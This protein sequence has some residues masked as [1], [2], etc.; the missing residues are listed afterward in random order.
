MIYNMERLTNRI[1]QLDKDDLIVYTKGKY[2][3][4]VPGE[5]SHDDIRAVLKKLAYYEDA[6][7]EREQ[8]DKALNELKRRREYDGYLLGSG[9][10]ESAYS[11]GYKKAVD[12]LLKNANEMS[13]EMSTEVSMRNYSIKAIGI[14][15]LEQ[16]AEQLK[17]GKKMK[18]M[19]KEKVMALLAEY[20]EKNPLAA[21]CGSE[22]IMQ[23]D[24]AQKDALEL[25]CNIFDSMEMR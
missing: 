9:I 11:S 19:D 17:D 1:K 12:D 7:E 24:E 22:Y 4:T 20:A 10:V 13:A 5:M 3:D 14:G 15:L 21:E 6:E 25:V 8:L 18:R 23:D 2:E 16:I